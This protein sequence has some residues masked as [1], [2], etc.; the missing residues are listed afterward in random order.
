VNSVDADTLHQFYK[1]PNFTGVEDFLKK[2][3]KA[4]G[5]LQKG[6]VLDIKKAINLV[7]EDWSKHKITFHTAPPHLK[8]H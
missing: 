4:T 1:I 7:C 5:Q 2:V 6:G 3:A 8:K